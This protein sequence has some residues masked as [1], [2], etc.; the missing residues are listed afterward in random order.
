MEK[1]VEEIENKFNRLEETILLK[2]RLKLSNEIDN[3]IKDIENTLE[4]YKKQLNELIFC[5]D[6]DKKEELS[7]EQ[8]S[9]LMIKISELKENLNVEEY[10]DNKIKL[11]ETMNSYINKCKSYYLQQKMEIN[12]INY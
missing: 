3:D 10:L 12:N 6:L 11:Y 4:K 9:E 1:T 5:E 8:V 2:K 7:D